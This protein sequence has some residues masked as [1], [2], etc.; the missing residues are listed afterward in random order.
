MSQPALI[1]PDAL[2]STEDL[3][4]ATR[5][6]VDTD[7]KPLT[8]DI[9]LEGVYPEGVLR[10]LGPLGAFRYHLP[11]ARADGQHDMPTAIQAMAEVSHEC[12]STGFTVWCQDT[13]GWYLQNATNAQN[14]EAIGWTFDFSEE[15]PATGLPVLPAFTST[16]TT[17]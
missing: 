13:C 3:L 7:L 1:T 15:D 11:A 12:L 2:M 5:A 16:G 14:I 9:D 8:V 6:V 10:K 17:R 4:R